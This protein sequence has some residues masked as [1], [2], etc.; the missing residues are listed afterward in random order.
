MT[1]DARI[2][3]RFTRR[4]F[5]QIAGV[6]GVAVT[7][8]GFGGYAAAQTPVSIGSY[9][10]APMLDEQDLPPVAERIPVT[11]MVVE[12]HESIGRYGGEWRT[13]MVGGA[14]GAWLEKI[15]GNDNLVRW[16][17]E[18]TEI[19]PNVAESFEMSDDARSCTFTLREGHRW[20]DG[21][22]FTTEDIRFYYEDLYLNEEFTLSP[23]VNPWTL[24]I[25]DEQTFTVTFTDPEGLFL[26]N[27]ASPNGLNWTR[28]PAHY[29]KQFHPTYNTD[30]LDQLLEEN[31][32]ADWLELFAFKGG[33]A[34]G[35]QV[36][37]TYTNPE[38][39]RLHAWKLVQPYGEGTQVTF[40]RNPYYFKVDPE[41][42][43]LPYIDKVRFDI[44]QNNEVL[45]LK[46]SNG[47][48]DYHGRHIN[49]NTNKPVLAENRETGDYD[50]YELIQSQMNTAVFSVNQTHKNPELREVFANKDFRLGLSHSIN[51]Q[52][53]IDVVFIGQG[54][55]WHLAPRQETPFY[56]ESLAKLGT[57]FNTD[58]ANEFL[59]KVLPEKDSSGARLLPSG[60]K[61]TLVLE[62]TGDQDPA[63]VDC[64]NM[65]GQYWTDVG[66]TTQV[67]P[68]DRSLMYQRKEANEHDC[69]V[70]WGDGGLNDAILDPRWYI[71]TTTESN[72]G[73]PW[74]Y[75]YLKTAA[76][77]AEA[78]EPPAPIKEGL[79]LYDALQDTGDPAEQQ[80][81]MS[82]I[83]AMAEEQFH[84]I[85]ISLPA[86]GYGIRKNYMRNVPAS[87]FQAYLYP[88]PSPTN[89]HT[90]WF[91]V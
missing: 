52:E 78:E 89:T 45:L 48:I 6:T 29:L 39:P 54:E 47:E 91:D 66:V 88:T 46:A 4:R 81:L 75:W 15:V 24:E 49:T 18:W 26:Q 22:P 57:E 85:G 21:E 20:S 87:T 11:P 69:C 32:A 77:S 38:L 73:V 3:N 40:E 53:I 61:L 13:G 23:G 56:S 8:T 50:F 30:T 70:W 65:V 55:P 5:L 9:Q 1:E 44:F 7:A 28:Y 71:P 25:Q 16:N 67:K 27:I 72:Y 84:A 82:Q 79:A 86:P 43:Q 35:T 64:A 36:S 68:E 12:P 2:P 41:G 10:Q 59:D 74:A 83:L 58:L 17:A 42:N 76:P 90:F 63:F 33:Q 34:A 19:I 80:E 62:V 14:D 51:R 37:A 60:E 31:G